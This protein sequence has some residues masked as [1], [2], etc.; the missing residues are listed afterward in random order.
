MSHVLQIGSVLLLAV[1]VSLA[2]AQKAQE[3]PPAAKAPKPVAKPAPA[4]KGGTP[5]AG[6][7]KAIPNGAARVINPTG[8]ATRLFRMTPEQRERALEPLPPERQAAFRKTLEWFDSLPKEQQEMQ[9]HRIER[10]DALTPEKKA[11]FRQ[12][13]MALDQ[14]PGPRKTLI[15]RQLYLLQEMPDQQRENTLKRPQFQE[16]FTPEEL[17]ILKGLADAW[18]PPQ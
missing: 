12:L 18:N 1:G 4:P 9:I 3:P 8:V 16:R 7:P 2:S 13:L 14:L 5:K 6:T 15:G 10:F 11:E 17:R